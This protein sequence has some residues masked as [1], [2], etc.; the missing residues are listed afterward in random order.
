MGKER[1]GDG[2]RYN[3]KELQ[4]E[5]ENAGIARMTLRRAAQE[6]GVV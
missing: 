3:G 6:A 4:Q 1:L 2:G 5:A